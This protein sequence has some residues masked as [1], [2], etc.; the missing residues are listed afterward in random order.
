M[1]KIKSQ[2]QLLKSLFK[3]KLFIEKKSCIL[4]TEAINLISKNVV[5]QLILSWEA[6]KKI[7]QTIILT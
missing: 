5:K 3:R 6:E 1:S 4:Q 7:F 2:I